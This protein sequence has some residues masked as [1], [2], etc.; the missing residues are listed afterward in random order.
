MKKDKSYIW[1]PKYNGSFGELKG[2]LTFTLV[3]YMPD[4]EIYFLLCMDTS[5]DGIGCVLM[6][7][8]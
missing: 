6:Q 7:E 5:G 8:G 1:M 4:L 3:L 2:L